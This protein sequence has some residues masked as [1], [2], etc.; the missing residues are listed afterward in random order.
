MLLSRLTARPKLD[1]FVSAGW[2]DSD[3]V[4]SH[5]KDIQTSLM[6]L[7]LYEIILK[8]LA[9]LSNCEQAG[10]WHRVL[11]CSCSDSAARAG[12]FGL[13]D[14]AAPRECG[15]LRDRTRKGETVE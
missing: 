5:F 7:S 4:G 15:R 1:A 12:I 8:N 11:V 6:T 3:F 9:L 13:R 10:P 2:T 14:Q